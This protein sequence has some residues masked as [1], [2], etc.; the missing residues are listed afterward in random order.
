MNAI[1]MTNSMH[2]EKL[3]SVSRDNSNS[4]KAESR[5]IVSFIFIFLVM[6]LFILAGWRLLDPATLPI[7][8]VRIEGNFQHL[9]P[10]KMQ[11]MV[12][13]VISGGFF[14]LNVTSINNTLLKEPWVHWVSVQ[15]IWPDGLSVQVKEQTAIGHWNGSGLLN[16]SAERFSPQEAELI[17][18]LPFLSGPA[19]T[20][21]LVLNRY[22]AIQQALSSQNI[23][24]NSLSLSERR[25]WLIQIQ[26]GPLVILGRSDVETRI[27]RFTGSVLAGLG[28]DISRVKKIDMRYTNGFAVEWNNEPSKIIEPGLKNNG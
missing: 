16:A 5:S 11:T 12:S 7:K 15:R 6:T 26:Q 17:S 14:N 10:E 22:K 27:A 9:S 13:D 8:H 1:V 18:T 23:Q 25:A 4:D 20:Q 2:E 19:E 21:H 24:I 3:S 28:K